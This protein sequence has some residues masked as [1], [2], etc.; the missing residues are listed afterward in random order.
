MK[1][2]DPIKQVEIVARDLNGRFA[3]QSVARRNPQKYSFGLV[4]KAP[5]SKRRQ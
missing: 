3:E 5:R 2:L 1:K 4:P